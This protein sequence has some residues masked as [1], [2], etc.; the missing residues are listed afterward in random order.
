MDLLKTI[1]T[2]RSIRNFKDKDVE[3]K[4]IRQI[5]DTARW[6]PSACNL[7]HWLF[8]SIKD[9]SIKEKIIING[10][11]QKQILNAPVNIAVFYDK[12]LSTE[13]N[14]NIQSVSAAIQNITLMAHSLGLG[15]NWVA[16][17]NKPN[18]IRNILNVPDR[19]KILAIIMLGYPKKS[20]EL[21]AP[22]RKSI[23]QILQYEKYRLTEFDFP[24]SIRIK[25]WNQQQIINYQKKISRRGFELE[26]IKEDKINEIF[27]EIKDKI[28][29]ERVLDLFPFSGH[30]LSKLQKLNKKVF[31]KYASEEIIEASLLYNKELENKNLITKYN[32][33]YDTITMFY[34]IE[35]ISN[36]KETLS[37]VYNHLERDGNLIIVTRN[38]YSW[39]G[40]WDFINLTLLNK[41]ELDKSYFLGLHHIGPWEI[42]TKRKIKKLLKCSGFK[43]INIKGKYFFPVS[44]LENTV[45]IQKLESLHFIFKIL[46]HIDKFFETIRLNN[47]FGE[48]FIIT[49]KK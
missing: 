8:I 49:C 37:D 24:E 15:T 13:N 22:P 12:S 6:A 29:G 18:V 2:R 23:N 28:K 46:K 33:K 19:Y 11:V 34:T 42:L 16:G 14:A 25:E 27:D 45:T 35:H 41:N 26:Y 5:I 47:M 38:K 39:R 32:E 4:K 36:I 21:T 9:K 48:T 1:K 43:E 3:D 31:G 30:F 40:L 10:E 17:I 44:E 7:Q 20:V